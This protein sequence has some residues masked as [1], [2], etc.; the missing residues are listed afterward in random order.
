MG[1]KNN[2]AWRGKTKNRRRNSKT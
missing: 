2:R 1:F